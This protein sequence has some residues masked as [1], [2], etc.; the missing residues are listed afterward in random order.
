ML[1]LLD[2]CAQA[3]LVRF[4]EGCDTLY[5]VPAPGKR[6]AIYRDWFV[7]F[8]CR[9]FFRRLVLHYH[10]GGLAT[11]LATRATGPERAL[12]RL[13][14]G[15]ADIAIVLANALRADASAL[16]P[17]RVVVVANGLDVPATRREVDH[18]GTFRVLFLG[19]C[20]EE[21]GLFL[22]A[23]AVQAANRRLGIPAFSLTAAGSFVESVSALRFAALASRAPAELHYAGFMR[24]RAL[25]DLWATTN[26]LCLPTSYAHE[27]Q[28]LVLIEALARDV[29]VIATTWRAIPET[30]DQSGALL[31]APGDVA[32]LTEALLQLRAAP[33]GGGGRRVYQAHFTRERHLR[34]LAAALA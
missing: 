2:A 28:P 17:R 9:P 15:R 20:T 8:L 25:E 11:W 32:A 1:S 24:G 31:V 21:K 19:A 3:I 29:P 27:A 23:E 5:Y 13:L 22:A 4:Q 14:L 26:C 6:G 34:D 16:D 30:L 7:M 33:R 10:T 12:T 18:S